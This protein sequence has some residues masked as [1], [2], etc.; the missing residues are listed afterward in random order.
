MKIICPICEGKKEWYCKTAGCM[1]PC[2]DCNETGYI[3]KEDN[4]MDSQNNAGR[5]RKY[6]ISCIRCG[7]END[8]EM[9]AH[10]NKSGRMVGWIFTCRTCFEFVEGREL[11]SKNKEEG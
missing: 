4:K 2:Q 1:Y 6:T 5:T 10:R 7:S 11:H 3:I 9:V 8:L